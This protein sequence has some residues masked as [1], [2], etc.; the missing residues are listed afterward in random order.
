[1]AMMDANDTVLFY[2]LLILINFF[3][4]NYF[5]RPPGAMEARRWSPWKGHGRSRWSI[6]KA[7][8]NADGGR[9]NT[10]FFFIIFFNNT[11]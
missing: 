8:L 9:D 5:A 2:F 7:M 4:F 3:I 10:V 6:G 11:Y 1:M